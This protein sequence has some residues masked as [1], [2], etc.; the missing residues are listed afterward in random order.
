MTD[1]FLQ[2]EQWVFHRY[3]EVTEENLV[4]NLL[5]ILPEFYASISIYNNL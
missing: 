4:I 3:T 2:M 1:V 5:N